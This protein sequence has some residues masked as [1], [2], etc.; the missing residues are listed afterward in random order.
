MRNRKWT[1]NQHLQNEAIAHSLFVSRYGNGVA[2]RMVLI[3][4]QADAELAAQLLVALEDMNPYTMTAK[5][6]ATQLKS[7]RVIN[8]RVY[9][10][11][12]ESLTSELESFA[13][14][15]ATYQALMFSDALPE[16]I[17]QHVPLHQLTPQQVFA[18]AVSQPFQGRLLKE[19]SDKLETDRIERLTNAVRMGFLNGETTEQVVRR[20]RGTKARNWEDGAL[21]VSRANATS[22]VKTAINHVAATARQ[23]FA[24]ANGD[25]IK[26]KQWDSTLDNKTTPICIVRDRLLYT[27]D[28][29]PIDHKVPY[30]NGPGK[31]H[32][33]CRSSETYITKSWRELGIPVDEL[34]G[35]TRASMD[36]QV[37]AK[38][39]YREW[40][41][42]QSYARQE[43]VLGVTRAR[44]LSDGKL[45][46][47]EFFNDR[48]EM[49]TLE[50]L[51][52]I[53]ASAY[54]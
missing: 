9:T 20:V 17:L 35:T 47:D 10:S 16:A 49:L 4:N 26:A 33:C 1:V 45:T 22:V 25:L 34:D 8:Q 24:E 46:V 19:W 13:A 36:G 28:G 6:L 29:Q 5:R 15:E 39:N 3:L 12:S 37:P 38:T 52:Q 14:H 30:L 31:A 54:E 18:S 27:L 2:R 42:N 43:Q 41:T 53:D 32:Y 51:R 11:L 48:G 44:L 21:Q 7:V 50:Q 40:L 23:D